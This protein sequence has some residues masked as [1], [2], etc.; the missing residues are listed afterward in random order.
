MKYQRFIDFWFENFPKSMARNA[1]VARRLVRGEI[2]PY[3]HVDM[4]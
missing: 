1:L 4:D 2:D 3:A